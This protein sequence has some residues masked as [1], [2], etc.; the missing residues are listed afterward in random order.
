MQKTGAD[1]LNPCSGWNLK[2]MFNNI[3]ESPLYKI[4]N[5]RSIAV[6]GASNNITSMGTSQLLSLTTLGF[7]GKIYPVHPKEAQVQGLRAYKSVFDLPEVPDLGLIVLPTN[8][9]SHVLEECGQKGLKNAIIVSGGFKEVGGDGVELEEEI[10]NIARKYQIRFLGPNCIGV[11]NTYHKLNTT[12]LLYKANPGFIGMASQSGS[13]ITQMSDLLIQFGLGFSVGIS[14]GNEANVDIVD[15]IQYMAACPFT[16]VIGLYIETIRRGREFINTARAVVP[17]KPIVAFYAGGTAAGQRAGLAHTG[18][19]AGPEQLYEGVFRQGGIIRAQSIEELFDFCWILGGA[20]KPRGNK[21]IIQTHS[22]GPGVVAADAS[23]REELELPA[24]SPKTREALASFI[25][26]TGSIRNPVDLTFSRNYL[27]YSIDI[28]KALLETGEA[29]GLLVYFLFPAEKAATFLG[30]M[31]IA[32]NEISIRFGKIIEDQCKA[33]VSLVQKYQKPIIG[34]SFRTRDDLFIKTLQNSG[35][36]VLP[37]PTRAAKA[38][39]ALARYVRIRDCLLGNF[40]FYT[41][42]SKHTLKK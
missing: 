17:R 22:G 31:G 18:A 41:E 1:V 25:P 42:K 8:V 29:D 11:I 38:M 10:E 3:N 19:M 2:N 6:W 39:G 23:A 26:H 15:C 7:D 16:K 13:F 20:P 35:I 32:E 30:Q 4:L 33:I 40:P 5:P 24:L 34:F 37:S 21:V 14:V 36:P 9:V 27:D 28:L 12:F